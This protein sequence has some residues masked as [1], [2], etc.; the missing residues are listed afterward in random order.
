M[1]GTMAATTTTSAG[2]KTAL[3]IGADFVGVI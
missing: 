1:S 2:Q 3:S